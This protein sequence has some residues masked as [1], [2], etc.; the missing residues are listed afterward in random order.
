MTP[1]S[2]QPHALY[3]SCSTLAETLVSFVTKSAKPFPSGAC[4]PAHSALHYSLRPCRSGVRCRLPGEASAPERAPPGQPPT[5]ALDT[6]LSTWLGLDPSLHANFGDRLII[7]I[8]YPAKIQSGS[9]GPTHVA[10][11]NVCKIEQ[12]R[13]SSRTHIPPLPPPKECSNTSAN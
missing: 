12:L 9:K 2:L 1:F 13:K 6:R 7:R 4:T 8:V 11:W 10:S 3:P 5:Q